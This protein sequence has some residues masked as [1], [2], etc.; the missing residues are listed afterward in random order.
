[1]RAGRIEAL[2]HLGL[3]ARHMIVFARDCGNGRENASM[4]AERPKLAAEPA[5]P[6]TGRG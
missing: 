5:L 4:S 6:G 1:M 2:I 3:V